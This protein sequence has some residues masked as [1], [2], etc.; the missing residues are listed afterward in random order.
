[1]GNNANS[2]QHKLICPFNCEMTPL[3]LIRTPSKFRTVKQI[4]PFFLSLVDFVKEGHTLDARATQTAC[5]LLEKI[6]PTYFGK[7]D[8]G[9][10]IYGLVPTHSRSCSGFTESFVV[11]LTSSNEE[12]VN[13]SLILLYRIMCYSPLTSRFNIIATGFFTLLP[14]TFY[15]QERH[16]VSSSH[17]FLIGIVRMFM[18][19]LSRTDSRNICEKKQI[20][21]TSFHQTFMKMFLHPIQPFQEFLYRIRRRLPDS[22]CLTGLFEAMVEYSPFME[23]MT[24]QII[25]KLFEEGFSDEIEL[26]I[27]CFHPYLSYLRIVF[28]GAQ[29][30][31]SLGGNVPFSGG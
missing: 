3:F 26:H 17:L 31:H 27:R 22:H 11:L 13:A 4:S 21:M 7:F 15:T 10:I 9:K 14:H 23:Q 1:M 25:T 5:S 20:S 6:R 8:S 29:L 28:F 19:D 16:L 2:H 12:L 30:I 24:Q 18:T